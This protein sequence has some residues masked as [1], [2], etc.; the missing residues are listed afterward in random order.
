MSCTPPSTSLS[1]SVSID[2]DDDNIVVNINK[3]LNSSPLNLPRE[4]D[5]QL[6]TGD[7]KQEQHV[8]EEEENVN[9]FDKPEV[10]IEEQETEVPPESDSCQSQLFLSQTIHVVE[11]EAG[12]DDVLKPP[13]LRQKALSSPDFMKSYR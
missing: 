1:T 10:A 12:D 9:K 11:N 8:V 5:N 2:E 13:P 6:T 4:D 7:S 3:Q